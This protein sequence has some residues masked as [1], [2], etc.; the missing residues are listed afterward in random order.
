MLQVRSGEILITSKD[1]PT[2]LYP[3]HVKYDPNNKDFGLLRGE[4][5]IR[6][7]VIVAISLKRY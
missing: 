5:L 1:L 7:R 2:F 3:K 4:L 6:V